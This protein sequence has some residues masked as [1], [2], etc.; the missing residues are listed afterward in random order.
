[1][2]ET[3]ATNFM[4]IDP[5][6]VNKKLLEWG[7]SLDEI[8][9]KISSLGLPGIILI[10]AISVSSTTTYP[11]VAGLAGL[12]GPLGVLGGLGLLGLSTVIGDVI[13]GYGIETVLKLVYKE[14]RKNE[15][16]ES[17]IKEV[18]SLPISEI[19]KLHLKQSIEV[20]INTEE[21]V[22]PKQV[23]IIEE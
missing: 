1:M 15:T 22:S 23:E 11:V 21:P 16:Q 6:E 4:G 3:T 14:R 5:N 9:K 7:I 17:L 12:G 8:V 19:L 2:S 18:E 13:G 10:I 20:E